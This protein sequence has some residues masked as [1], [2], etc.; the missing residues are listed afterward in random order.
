MMIITV[1]ICRRNS[2]MMAYWNTE[3][4]VFS[5]KPDISS[6]QVSKALQFRDSLYVMAIDH[7]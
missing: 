5:K 7:P 3:M 1:T 4:M 2:G 6:F